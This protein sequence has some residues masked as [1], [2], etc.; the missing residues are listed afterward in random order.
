MPCDPRPEDPRDAIAYAESAL[1]GVR[2]LLSQQPMG[3]S[4]SPHDVAAVLGVIHD[5]MRPAVEA[6]Q[7][8]APKSA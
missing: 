8:Y 3:E 5:R 7:S 6:I 1:Y 4:V 2:V